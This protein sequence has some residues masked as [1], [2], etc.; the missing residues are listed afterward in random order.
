[1][2]WWLRFPLLPTS[3]RSPLSLQCG[4]QWSRVEILSQ[5]CCLSQA[6]LP[7]KILQSMGSNCN[8][9]LLRWEMSSLKLHRILKPVLAKRWV[10]SK[11]QYWTMLKC[12]CSAA[13]LSGLYRP[14]KS[15]CQ[16]MEEI[17]LLKSQ[18]IINS[19]L[20]LQLCRFYKKAS[21]VICCCLMPNS[22]APVG[23]QLHI[24]EVHSESEGQS[25]I[26]MMDCGREGEQEQLMVSPWTKREGCRHPTPHT[27]FTR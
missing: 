12:L 17:Q 25:F 15:C 4:Q 6:M 13:V 1:M 26:S 20:D 24:G 19:V 22:A 16:Q 9:Q 5:S 8:A 23:K 18:R 14:F 7:R 21:F 11:N 2:A 3:I 10:R 27:S